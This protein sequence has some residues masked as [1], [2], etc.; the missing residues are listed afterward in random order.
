MSSK[1]TPST[2]SKDVLPSRE[3]RGVL[4]GLAA[5][6]MGLCVS[7]HGAAAAQAAAPST[8]PTAAAQP[9]VIPFYGPHQAGVTTPQPHVGLVVSF[10]VLV[11][12]RSELRQLFAD[13]TGL[14]QMLA[15]G[16]RPPQEDEKFPPADNGVLGIEIKPERLTATLAA[17]SSLF[18]ER[19]G[20]ARLKPKQLVEM[21]AFSN[22]ALDADLCHGDLLIQFCA[23]TQE[24]VIH[25][26]RAV[27]KLA[28]DKLAVRWK[29]EGFASSHGERRNL[30]GTGRNLLG[31]KDGTANANVADAALMNDYVW[32]QTTSGEPAWTTGGSYQVVRLIRNYVEA[33]DRTPLGEQQR[34]FGRK[35]DS[36]AAIGASEEFD[37]PNYAGDPEGKNVPLDAHIRL[38]NPRTPAKTAKLIRRGFNY[39]NGVTKAGQ[40]DMGLLFVSFQADLQKGFLD[41]QDRLS[42]EPLEE[43]I[44]PFGGGY[45][46][47]LPGVAGAGNHL[48]DALFA[49][50]DAL[51]ASSPP[52]EVANP[53]KKG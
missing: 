47:V 41:T 18:D 1:Q 2:S 42:G 14:F 19:F 53:P 11:Q 20:L 3:R 15:E 7:A 29:Q 21:K 31:F 48:G 27:I 22:D 5:G 16:G 9:I 10:E 38:A 35:K 17:G 24:E 26:L 36:G 12:K 8:P 51:D 52:S 44:K 50:A 49:A 25:A 34:I 40:L 46:F 43:Y 28:P 6:G 37:I 33:W 39:S 45:F 30:L 4:L 32:V 23:E 13:L